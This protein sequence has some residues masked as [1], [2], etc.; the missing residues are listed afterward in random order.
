MENVVWMGLLYDFYGGLLTPKQQRVFG[1]YYLDNLSLA[2]IAEE[3][4]TTR[5]AV[6][7][8]LQRTERLLA[9]WESKLGLVARYLQELEAVKEVKEAVEDLD[10]L[11]PADEQVVRG[12]ARVRAALT[13][14]FSVL[15]LGSEE[16]P[17]TKTRELEV[18][19]GDKGSGR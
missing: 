16:G 12:L 13:R 19:S 18:K 4:G 10:R 14:L 11:R 8:L 15:E 17:G 2:E 9:G 6:H 1:L 5:Q 3:E 7:D